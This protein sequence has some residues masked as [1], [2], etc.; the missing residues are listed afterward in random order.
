MKIPL[1][2]V[3]HVDAATPSWPEPLQGN[4]W[5]KQEADHCEL[6][7]GLVLIGMMVSEFNRFSLYKSARNQWEASKCF[8]QNFDLS[9]WTSVWLMDFQISVIMFVS[10]HLVRKHHPCRTFTSLYHPPKWS[11]PLF[12]LWIRLWIWLWIRIS[13]YSHGWTGFGRCTHIFTVRLLHYGGGWPVAGSGQG[14]SG[15]LDSSRSGGGSP[16]GGGSSGGCSSRHGSVERGNS[17]T[18]PEK[19][20]IGQKKKN[21]QDRK[22]CSPPHLL[23]QDS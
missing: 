3:S 6:P 20:Q 8:L 16:A 21:C 13:E 18:S 23:Q 1:V 2:T 4:K 7:S 11:L 15:S 10:W 9:F 17:S 14:A 5:C 12:I 22:G 19:T